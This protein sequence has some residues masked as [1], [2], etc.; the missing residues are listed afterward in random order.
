M[1]MRASFAP[2]LCF[3]LVGISIP[4]TAYAYIDPGTGSLILQLILAGILGS[5]FALKT[6]WRKVIAFFKRLFTSTDAQD[7]P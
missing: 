2:I 7:E 5:L 6:F 1:G 4:E 3:V